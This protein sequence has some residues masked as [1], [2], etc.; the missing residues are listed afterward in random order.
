MTHRRRLAAALLVCLFA[1]ACGARMDADLHKQAADAILGGGGTGTTVDGSGTGAAGGTTDGTTDT[2]GGAGTPDSTGGTGTTGAT[3]STG[4]TSTGTTGGTG[5]TGSTGST[6]GG[7]A[8]G[9]TGGSGSTGGKSGSGGSTGSGAASGPCKGTAK[10]TGLTDKQ[11]TLGT[12][13]SLTGPVPGLFEGAVQGAQTFAAYINGTGGIC[14]RNIKVQPADDGTNCSQ[15]QNVT[16]DL[17]GKVFAFVGTF[18]LYDGCGAKVL[19]AKPQVP[20]IHARLDPA[21]GAIPNHFDIEFGARGYANGMFQY[22]A[23]KYPN[24]VKAV[25]TLY[26]NIPSAAGLQQEFINSAQTA[27]WKFLYNRGHDATETD[28]TTDFVK[29]CNQ[30]VKLFFVAAE[31][32]TNAAKMFNNERSAGCPKLI[33]ISPI[34]YDQALVKAVGNTSVIEGLQGWNLFV[35][36]FNKDEAARSPELALF[37]QWFEKTYPGKPLNLYA[38]F[39]WASGRLFQQAYTAA[40]PGVNRAALLAELRKIKSFDAN[41]LVAPLNPSD[42]TSGVNCYVLW[43]FSGGQFKRVAPATGFRC[44]GQFVVYKG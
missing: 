40:G 7:T 5:T 13:A 36:F 8:A 43:Q 27:G 26:P 15:N 42:R 35:L 28:F 18:S 3:G 24:E 14:G 44:D 9:G 16:E 4:G 38:L 23:K 29:M 37:Q 32:A 10:D 17:A 33:N 2:T 41:G 19:K 11:V 39:S 21:A 31:N 22:F 20:D 12:V 25:G 1:S 34:A 6:G 30:G